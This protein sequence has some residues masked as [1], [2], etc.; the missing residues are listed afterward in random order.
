MVAFLF[1]GAAAQGQPLS[2]G[3]RAGVPLTDAYASSTILSNGSIQAF[4]Q[5]TGYAIG[6][7]AELHLPLGL[8]IEVDALYRPLEVSSA[9]IGPVTLSVAQNV[10][11][12]EFP[13]VGKYRF[14]HLPV[15]KP[16]LET[17][18]SFRH[19]GASYFSNTGFILG[20]GVEIKLGRL[21]IEPDIRY[22]RW[23]A[24]AQTALTHLPTQENQAEFLLGIAF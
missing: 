19:V 21:R 16:Y 17:G 8:S 22:D 9:S 7:M 24:D 15:V 11:S 1:L 6:P 4:S 2:F 23:G 14:L 13:I 20:I 18:P 3:I 5:S 10:S 12:W